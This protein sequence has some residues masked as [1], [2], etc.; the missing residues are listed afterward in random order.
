MGVGEIIFSCLQ[1]GSHLKP[2]C[3]SSNMRLT[4][5]LGLEV[6]EGCTIRVG[7]ETRTWQEGECLWFDDSYEHEVWHR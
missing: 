3:A 5:H 7:Q 4:C 1:P 2:H 6:P